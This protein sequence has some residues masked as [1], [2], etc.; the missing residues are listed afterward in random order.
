M[1]SFQPFIFDQSTEALPYV[2]TKRTEAVWYGSLGVH[3][4]C[5]ISNRTL[6]GRNH[7][8]G[9]SRIMRTWYFGGA[10]IRK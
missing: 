3:M 10:W 7:S 1:L 2:Y 8:S 5:G 4:F 9:S 6:F